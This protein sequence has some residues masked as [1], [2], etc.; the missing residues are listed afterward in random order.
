MDR[1]LLM[2][3]YALRQI[4]RS[5]ITSVLFCVLLALAGA[6]LCL[7]AGLLTTALR[8][9][10]SIKSNYTTIALPD[11][12]AMRRYAL[13]KIESENITEYDTGDSIITPDDIMWGPFFKQF[14][15][16]H[17][18][19]EILSVIEEDV[20]GSPAVSMDP[21]RCYGAYSPGVIPIP[22]PDSTLDGNSSA[23][24]VVKCT[25]IEEIQRVQGKLDEQ[26]FVVTT[27]AYV[28]FEVLETVM[29][30]PDRR[31]PDALFIM[32]SVTDENGGYFFEVGGTYFI[33]GSG[34]SESYYRSG[35]ASAGGTGNS[36]NLGFWDGTEV[37]VGRAE[38][39]D[40]LSE[41]L[42][43]EL[44]R[45]FTFYSVTEKD[46]P[47]DIVS[48]RYT[49]G[50]S[51]RAWFP[52]GADLQAALGSDIGA[53]IEYALSVADKD[54]RRLHV[55]TTDN[56]N[57]YF[58]FNQ[59]QAN[60]DAGRGFTREEAESG[61][62][63]CLIP[64]NLAS[65]NEL[66]IGDTITLHLTEGQ[67]YMTRI[68]YKDNPNRS[69]RNW[70]TGG[71]SSFMAEAEPIEFEIVG[72]YTTSY[73]SMDANEPH[74]I[75]MNTVIIPDKSFDGSLPI[76]YEEAPDYW[77]GYA[78]LNPLLNVI[79]VPNGENEAFRE[80]I[81]SLIPG[82]GNFFILYDQGYSFVMNAAEN[83]RSGSGLVFALSAAG[84][85]ISA[86]VFHLFFVLRK[87]KEAGLLYA[88]G[89]GKKH[90]FVWVFA[91]CA[92]IIVA[93]QIAAFGASAAL[94]G[95]VLEYAVETAGRDA[96]AVNDEFSDA[97]SVADGERQD[98]EFERDPL[99]VPAAAAAQTALLLIMAGGVSARIAKRGAGSLGEAGE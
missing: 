65:K 35:S 39:F 92:L 40:D 88:L 79:V 84:W 52:L 23:A 97:V 95:N 28:D 6:L 72:T 4:R 57:S 27:Q 19:D 55:L 74:A 76:R 98:F 73:P 46:F 16:D 49:G 70:R 59:R 71:Y 94:Y 54:I 51:Y 26:R 99:A 10:G 45:G 13:N 47:M 63:V 7:G 25:G 18:T 14:T 67:F 9:A 1:S 66:G 64:A 56:L 69:Y 53:D 11:T 21:R 68:L 81:N 87:K 22:Q 17:M 32:V 36:M 61:A 80:S 93:A 8:S 43:R 91:Q 75:P 5:V 34:Y 37:V 83:L 78:D 48:R 82:Y 15:A 41:T 44:E 30:H 90:R 29:L 3:K 62:K 77:V 86:A 42:R 12:A 24:F 58:Y 89:I 60:I 85:L 96:A 2:Y 20:Y 33:S 50:E 31:T 38:T